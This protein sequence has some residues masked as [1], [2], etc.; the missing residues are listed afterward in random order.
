MKIQY[1]FNM[2]ESEYKENYSKKS[3]DLIHEIKA[4]TIK[5]YLFLY[6]GHHLTI[7]KNF[8]LI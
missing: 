1:L 5:G 2:D 8:I 3:Y 7:N 6:P 4:S